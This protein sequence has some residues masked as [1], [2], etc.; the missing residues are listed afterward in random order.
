MPFSRCQVA[1]SQW[2]PCILDNPPVAESSASEGNLFTTDGA[3][4]VFP[5]TY[6]GQTINSCMALQPGGPQMCKAS[7]CLARL[8]PLDR[9]PGLRSLDDH[10]VPILKHSGGSAL[11]CWSV[12][13]S[14]LGADWLSRT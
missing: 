11:S 13:A 12:I 6:G 3:Q 7:A 8:L 9:S 4:C 5:A 10:V 14:R 1:E 2:E